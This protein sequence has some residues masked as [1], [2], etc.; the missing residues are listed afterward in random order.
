LESDSAIRETGAQQRRGSA[1]SGQKCKWYELSKSTQMIHSL[2]RERS[3]TMTTRWT[4][5]G[6]VAITLG[7]APM[8]ARADVTP[9][10][11]EALTRLDYATAL[12]RAD[13]ALKKDPASA[14]LLYNKGCA[15]VGLNRI[16]E[17]VNVLR[18]AES[19]FGTDVRGASIAAYRRAIAFDQAGRCREA[20][21]EYAH[22]VVVASPIDPDGA[23]LAKTYAA[24]CRVGAGTL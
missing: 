11:A 9:E 8:G 18:E 22:Y 24:A 10:P 12:E 19:R 23:R 2:S 1:Q 16:E 14:W 17:G 21:A 15:L 5:I 20:K 4:L 6:M 3:T 7:V 13:E